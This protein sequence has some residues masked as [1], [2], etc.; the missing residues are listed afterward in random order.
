HEPIAQSGDV[1]AAD[2]SVEREN[3]TPAGEVLRQAEGRN[4]AEAPD[5]APVNVRLERM[6]SIFDQRDP[7]LAARYAELDDTVGKT[8]GVTCQ[9]GGDGRP[10]YPINCVDSR[11]S[12]LVRQRRHH[13]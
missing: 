2:L 3:A 12:I 8:V 9:N 10:R 11:V 7:E 13:P 5:G 4:S 1:P 6:G